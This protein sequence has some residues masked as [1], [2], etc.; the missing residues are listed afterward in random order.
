VKIDKVLSCKVCGH[1]CFKDSLLSYSNLPSSAQGFLEF[2]EL[3]SDIGSELNVVQCSVCGLVQL[4]NNP[5]SYYKE[6]I[7]ASAFSNEM[8]EFRFEQ[9]Q[10]WIKQYNLAN[11]KIIEVGCGKGEYLEIL[12]NAGADA[13]GIEYSMESVDY[14]INNNLSVIQGF[15]GN[16]NLVLEDIKYDGFMCLS[17]MEHWPEPN[18]V[19]NALCKNLKEGSIGLVEVPNFNMILEEGLYSEFISDHLLYFTRETLIFTLQL[20]GFEVLNCEAIWHNYILSAVVRKR[21]KTNLD[22]FEGFKN[23]VKQD[24]DCFIEKFPEKRVAIWGAGHQALATISLTGIEKK[25]KFIVDSAIFKQGKYSPSSHIQIVPEQR[26]VEDSVDAIIIMAGSYSD[27]ISK[28]MLTKYPSI[29][30]AVLREF[31]LEFI[32]N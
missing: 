3:E 13:Y 21:V 17:F 20:N 24:L 26:L 19:L 2:D 12:S 16:Q 30:I 7:R 4:D 8:K 27:E 28:I 22:F 31:G 25:I 6:V 10:S 1:D 23:K 9:F 29:E 15:L 11:K 32:E 14:C 5:V 18:E